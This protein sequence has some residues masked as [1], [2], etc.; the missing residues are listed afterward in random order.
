MESIVVIIGDTES[1]IDV[2]SERY[3]EDLEVTLG[4]T[5]SPS[6]LVI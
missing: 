3:D 1:M 5:M 2:L 6:L 4:L